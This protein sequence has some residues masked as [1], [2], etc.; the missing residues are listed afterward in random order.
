MVPS[1]ILLGSILSIVLTGPSADVTA[2]ILNGIASGTFIYIALV[3]IL[4]EQFTDAK[5]KFW[6]YMFC[7]FGFLSITGMFLLF[8]EGDATE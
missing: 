8:D 5:H 6:K 1:G 3:D 7:F 4:L 2:A